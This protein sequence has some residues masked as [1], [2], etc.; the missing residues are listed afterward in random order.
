MEAH[1]VSHI[2]DH[3]ISGLSFKTTGGT[4][5]YLTASRFVLFQAESGDLWSTS[6][7][8]IRFRIASFDFLDMESVRLHMTVH[9]T[10]T[11]TAGGANAVL[12]PILPAMGMFQRCRLYVA[13]ALVEDI[14]NVGTL[15]AIMERLKSAPRRYNDAMESGHAMLGGTDAPSFNIDDETLTP[16][17]AGT[18]RRTISK[19]PF[20]LL[21][22]DKWMPLSQVAAGGVVCELELS[23]NAWQAFE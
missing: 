22:Q 7:R 11:V 10:T 18:A 8:T 3:L 16:M 2:Q 12:T 4:S 9:N 6:N 5:N 13:G 19:L 15:T 14:D 21:A 1:V 23:S 20:G 17:A